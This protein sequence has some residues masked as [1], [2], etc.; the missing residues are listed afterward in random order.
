[1]PRLVG[2]HSPIG[3]LGVPGGVEL[4]AVSYGAKYDHHNFSSS[5]YHAIILGCINVT[6]P[7]VY[8]NKCAIGLAS[9]NR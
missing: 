1:M 3:P 8:L 4:P 7:F 5:T 6:F 9:R 2:L